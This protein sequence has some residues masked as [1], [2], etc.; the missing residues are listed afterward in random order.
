MSLSS[1]VDLQLFASSRMTTMRCLPT[2]ALLLLCFHPMVSS[3]TTITSFTST[4]SW[5]PLPMHNEA[6][7]G[8]KGGRGVEKT[9]L[10]PR[11]EGGGSDGY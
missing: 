3:A 11:E 4:L 6:H 2:Q 1:V 8:E 9:L 10:T 5:S 7:D